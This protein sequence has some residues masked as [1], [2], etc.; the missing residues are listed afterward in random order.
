MTIKNLEGIE[1]I[2]NTGK[3]NVFILCSLWETGL[4]LDI[5]LRDE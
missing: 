2:L 3:G 5:R 4:A 1:C